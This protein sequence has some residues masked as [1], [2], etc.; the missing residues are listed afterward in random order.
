M[1]IGILSGRV[2][3]DY[4]YERKGKSTI[5]VMGNRI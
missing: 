2:K 5:K 4:K 1:K 3:G